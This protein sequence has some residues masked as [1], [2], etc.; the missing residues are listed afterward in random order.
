MVRLA[1]QNQSGNNAVPYKCPTSLIKFN[2]HLSIL[3][4]LHYKSDGMCG[5]VLFR[6]SFELAD[7]KQHKQHQQTRPTNK[8]EKRNV[9]ELWSCLS[10]KHVY[11]FSSFTF[12]LDCSFFYIV[13]PVENFPFLHCFIRKIESNSGWKLP[14]QFS[15]AQNKCRFTDSLF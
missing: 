6:Y 13:V 9:T 5:N 10:F 7:E 15:T 11:F 3:V 12:S 14:K 4:I 2:F 8:R 1:N